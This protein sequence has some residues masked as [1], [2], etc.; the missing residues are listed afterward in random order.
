MSDYKVL[1]Y[2]N[3]NIIH[4]GHIRLINY[5]KEI[6]SKIIIG[7]FA[8]SYVSKE[9]LINEKSRINALKKI[10]GIFKVTL[11]KNINET[12][13]DIKPD[14]VLKG[15]EHKEK[16]NPEI[17]IINQIGAK[18][19]F[20]HSTNTYSTI[21]DKSKTNADFIR[22]ISLPTDYM[23]RHKISNHEIY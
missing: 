1:I 7:V 9:N 15:I 12:L 6:G 21:V 2:G 22:S 4:A 18:L 20:G 23:K 5:A 19:I 13:K 17:K 11:V 10:D 8:D 3:F 16:E 14:F